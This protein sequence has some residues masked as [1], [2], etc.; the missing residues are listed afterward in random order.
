MNIFTKNKFENAVNS[1]SRQR[2][3]FS[4]ILNE[5]R[6]YAN[7]R[8]GQKTIFLS[9]SHHD[10]RYVNM[11]RAFFERLG[12]DLYVDWADESMPN[13]TCGYTA[14]KIKE[15][16]RENDFFILLA[17]DL[18]LWSKWCNW[19]LG[20]GDTYKY[21]SD[22][23]AILPLADDS[24]NWK[25]NEYIQT[26]PYIKGPDSSIWDDTPSKYLIHYPDGQ[27]RSLLNWLQK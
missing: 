7:A 19:E 14:L 10:A 1:L 4:N 20:I 5:T 25:G 13:Y 27:E 9:H 11:T 2:M 21:V 12:I 6:S 3:T 8:Y 26:Y 18:A 24:D 15:K 17:T 22:R 23:L 16:I